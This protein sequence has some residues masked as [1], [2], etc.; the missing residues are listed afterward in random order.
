[1][2]YQESYV[3]TEKREAFGRLIEAIKKNAKKYYEDSMAEPVEII[4]LK[5]KIEGITFES[6]CPKKCEFDAGEQFVYF[7]GDRHLQRSV[8]TLL[9][10]NAFPGVE[11]YFTED[12]PS[13][14]MFEKPENYK[15]EVVYEND[16]AKHEP[17]M[18]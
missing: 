18:W 9:D 4:T 7:S 11:I 1:M 15:D 3:K 17:F 10:K 8:N 6:G 2:G 13:Y 14:E 16:F 12:L 5:R